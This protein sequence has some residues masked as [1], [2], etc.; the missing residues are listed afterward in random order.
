MSEV[1]ER[2]SQAQI[3]CVPFRQSM[4]IACVSSKQAP[5]P[6]NLT[7][8]SLGHCLAS[9][10]LASS[11]LASEGR[12]LLT[13][14]PRAVRCIGRTH[15]RSIQRKSATSTLES[16]KHLSSVCTVAPHHVRMGHFRPSSSVKIE[17][18]WVQ[19]QFF[20]LSGTCSPSPV[21]VLGGLG[22]RPF[23]SVFAHRGSS[24][25][26]RYVGSRNMVVCTPPTSSTTTHKTQ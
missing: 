11:R 2:S 14:T 18:K 15:S 24:I 8:Q 16:G 20:I 3:S 9:S 17:A 23:F 22:A 13:A 21:H 12:A 7:R 5:T 26:D 25:K 1:C 10:R 19:R 4:R 6:S